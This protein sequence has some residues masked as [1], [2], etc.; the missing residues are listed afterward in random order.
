MLYEIH[1]TYV[2]V[3]ADQRISLCVDIMLMDLYTI[4]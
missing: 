4:L 3:W 2:D 1:S